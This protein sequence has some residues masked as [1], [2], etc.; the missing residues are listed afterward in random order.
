VATKERVEKLKRQHSRRLLRLPG[1][2]GVG[3]ERAEEPDDYALVVHV[4]D[5][6]PATRAA[7]QEEVGDKPVRIV[8]SGKF[9]KL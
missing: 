4:E 3:I 5:D 1:V 2:S 8:R 7:V 9:R 6:S